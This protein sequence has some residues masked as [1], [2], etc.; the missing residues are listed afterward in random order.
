[1]Y[2]IGVRVQGKGQV[3][4]PQRIRKILN[5][6]PGDLVL[7][8]ETKAGVL[9]KPAELITA[10]DHKAEMDAIVH[11]IRERFA[12]YSPNEIE[13]LVNDAVKDVRGQHV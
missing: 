1:M 13:K 2:D 10:A 6:K 5:V 8:I 9:V 4:I 7:F 11:T 3:T 12:E